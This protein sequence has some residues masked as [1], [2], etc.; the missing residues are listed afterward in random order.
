MSEKIKRCAIYIRITSERLVHENHL[1]LKVISLH[2]R[3][4]GMIP[5]GVY[6]DEG[7]TKAR[8]KRLKKKRKRFMPSWRM[9][10]LVKL[11]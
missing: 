3:D 5:V 10:K 8:G 1:R 6:A 9:S 4:H 11:M 7:K 2:A